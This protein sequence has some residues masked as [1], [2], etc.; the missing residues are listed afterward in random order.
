[1]LIQKKEIYNGSCGRIGDLHKRGQYAKTRPYSSLLWSGEGSWDHQEVRNNER[2]AEHRAARP[3]A[4]FHKEF[5]HRQKIPSPY[6]INLFSTLQAGR[7]GPSRSILPVTLFNIRINSI[8]KFL[9]PRIEDYLNVD[10]FCIT[11]RPKY[12]RTAVR[13]L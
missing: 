1:M 11:H 3:I 4:Q 6:W 8:T 7:W 12:T 5:S 9:T 10:N 2:P 13:Q